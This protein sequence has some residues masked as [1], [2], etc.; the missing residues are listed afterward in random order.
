M[1]PLSQSQLMKESKIIRNIEAISEEHIPS[2]LLGRQSQDH[3]LRLCLSPAL[4]KRKPIN[5]WLYG[6]PGTG[7]T[8]V[9]KSVLKQLMEETGLQG[10][11]INCWEHTS[12]YSIADKLVKDLKIMFAERPDTTLKLERFRKIIGSKPFVIVLDEID[13]PSPKERNNILYSLTEIGNVGLICIC[14]SRYTLLELD[15]RI[16]S[17]LA[18]RQIGFSTY[19][20]DELANILEQ[21]A[22]NAFNAEC[23]TRAALGQIAELSEGDART[24]V[25]ILRKAAELAESSHVDNILNEHITEA[26]DSTRELRKKYSLERLSEHH[27]LIYKVIN[28]QPGN[29]SGKIWEAYAKSCLQKGKKPIATRTFSDYIT[30]LIDLNLIKAEYIGRNV[31]AFRIAQ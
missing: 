16:Q 31:R 14:N 13:K 5:T 30:K 19:S 4:Q 12:L 26:W 8:A 21:R 3:E 1:H 18:P 15:D 25:Q 2:S 24:S 29:S 11:Y 28:E 9:A 22:D 6:K 20:S 10:I 17:R 23:W 7:K 27:K